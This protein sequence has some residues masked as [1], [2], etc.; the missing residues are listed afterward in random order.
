MFEVT[1]I[2]DEELNASRALTLVLRAERT[3]KFASLARAQRL[4]DIWQA[5]YMQ[6][7]ADARMRLNQQRIV[8]GVPADI[9]G[10]QHGPEV[11]ALTDA[12]IPF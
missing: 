2:T 8:A 10:A 1:Q 9:W 3:R 5:R 12:D 11:R 7:R 4:F 6:V